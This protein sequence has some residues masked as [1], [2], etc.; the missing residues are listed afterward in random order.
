MCPFGMCSEEVYLE[1]LHAR[2]ALV[3]RYLDGLDGRRSGDGVQ[4][5]FDPLSDAV[6]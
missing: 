6:A 2:V 4:V 1:H 5:E 3:E